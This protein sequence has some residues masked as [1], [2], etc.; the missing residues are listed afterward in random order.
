[1]SE[2]LLYFGPGALS[3]CNKGNSKYFFVISCSHLVAVVVVV[4]DY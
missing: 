4:C 2:M 3:L 1:M